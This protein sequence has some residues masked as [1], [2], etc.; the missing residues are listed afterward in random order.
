[1]SDLHKQVLKNQAK[2]KPP[3]PKNDFQNDEGIARL[4]TRL[5]RL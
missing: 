1:M 5:K 4:K 2:K 3:L